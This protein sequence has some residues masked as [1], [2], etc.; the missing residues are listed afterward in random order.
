MAFDKEQWA[1]LQELRQ[2][3]RSDVSLDTRN[4]VQ[5]IYDELQHIQHRLDQIFRT[6]KE[7]IQAAYEDIEKVKK[8]VKQIERRLSALER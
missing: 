1:Q 7:D 2:G 5:P 8:K 3:I 4:L 6:E